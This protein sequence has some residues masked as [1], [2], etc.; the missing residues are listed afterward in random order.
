MWPFNS[1]LFIPA[2]KL[3][4]VRKVSRFSPDAVILDLED[5]VPPALKASARDLAR[6]GVGLLR[7]MDIAPFV[8]VNE[9]SEGGPADVASV[10]V[11]GLAGIVLPKAHAPE[12]VHA[13]DVALA[14][15]EGTSGMPLGAVAI[16]PLPETAQG[17]HDGRQLAA[18]SSRCKGLMGLVGGPISGD[19]SRAMGFIPTLEG[20]E[21]LYLASKTV[22]DSRAGGAPYPVAS[23][24]GTRLDDLDAVRQLCLRAKALGFSGAVLIHPSHVAVANQV[25]APTPEEVEH[26]LGLLD[27]IRAAEEAGSAAV[28]YRGQMVDYAMRPRAEEILAQARRRGI[29]AD[30]TLVQRRT[31][32]DDT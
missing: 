9:W 6:E 25:F 19:V 7:G 23:I 31:Q 11:P 21:Q 12:Q 27:A 16:L 1:M 15:A 18:A 24:I 3:D 20:T 8:R 14:H 2:H 30:S 4:W 5:A 32:A 26:S 22:L 17:L 29:T 10:T 13:L 28:T